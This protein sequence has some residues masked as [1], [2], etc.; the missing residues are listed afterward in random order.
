M[1]A[2]DLVEIDKEIALTVPAFIA[3][4][5]GLIL[6]PIKEL[7]GVRHD[8][9]WVIFDVHKADAR[10]TLSIALGDKESKVGPYNGK[11]W[12]LLEIPISIR[13]KH[14]RLREE[15]VKKL[16]ELANTSR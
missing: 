6:G 14:K 13:R 16:K 9:D 3:E 5:P 11:C 15:V 7:K 8:E 10:V 4:L 2:A 12:I 1:G